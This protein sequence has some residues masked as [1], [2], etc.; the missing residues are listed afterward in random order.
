MAR[1]LLAVAASGSLPCSCMA[2]LS[3]DA[4]TKLVA[5]FG[6]GKLCVCTAIWRQ[7]CC[8]LCMC[9][10]AGCWDNRVG[11]GGS[12]KAVGLWGRVCGCWPTCPWVF[13]SSLVARVCVRVCVCRVV[14]ARVHHR[15]LGHAQQFELGEEACLAHTY[16]EYGTKEVDGRMRINGPG[17]AASENKAG[18]RVHA[19][20]LASFLCGPAC[21]FFGAAHS[22]GP[23]DMLVA[24]PTVEA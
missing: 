21:P 6:F 24:A 16:D 9:V 19:L 3:A 23:G 22:P 10:G 11:L 1:H 18:V 4:H 17:V 15:L 5:C 14:C 13:E 8:V 7:R 20:L 12:R 2:P